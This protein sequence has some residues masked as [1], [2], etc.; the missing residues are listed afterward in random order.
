MIGFIFI[1]VIIVNVCMKVAGVISW[2][3]WTVFW[4]LWVDLAWVIIEILRA[5]M[6]RWFDDMRY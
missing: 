2:S 4:P 1:V 3:W 6:D 5:C